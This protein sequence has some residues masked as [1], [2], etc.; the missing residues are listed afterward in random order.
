M[1]TPGPEHSAKKRRGEGGSSDPSTDTPGET[2][3]AGPRD[4]VGDG[5]FGSLA[6]SAAPDASPPTNRSDA[7]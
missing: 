6:S 5:T 3:L 7:R 1:Q 4:T 2:R